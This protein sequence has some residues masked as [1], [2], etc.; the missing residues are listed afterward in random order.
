MAHTKG[1]HMAGEMNEVGHQISKKKKSGGSDRGRALRLK[2]LYGRLPNTADQV[3]L[4]PDGG[5]L[6]RLELHHG[7]SACH[8]HAILFF[9]RRQG[10]F[11]EL[12]VVVSRAE[13]RHR[14]FE[15]A[16]WCAVV[17]LINCLF[18]RAELAHRICQTHA[19]PKI[20]TK[21]QCINIHGELMHP[22]C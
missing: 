6:F 1:Q 14:S 22:R 9:P 5:D 3:L 19:R 17:N 12:F 21:N 7:G 2:K 10:A 20:M 11:F 4:D 8:R 13:P 15:K 18:L 16:H